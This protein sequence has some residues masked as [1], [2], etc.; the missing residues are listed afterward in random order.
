[1]MLMRD[2][3][4]RSGRRR[5]SQKPGTAIGLLDGVRRAGG[6]RRRSGRLRFAPRANVAAQQGGEQ[7]HDA[8]ARALTANCNSF[9]GLE[10]RI[11]GEHSIAI[12]A[13][14]P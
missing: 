1:M 14:Q 11:R 5:G 4:G 10:A 8:A 7:R 6:G 13:G 12:V 3:S 9:A 2:R